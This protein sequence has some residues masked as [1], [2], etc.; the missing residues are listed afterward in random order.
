MRPNPE[1]LQRAEEAYEDIMIPARSDR[2]VQL[3]DA[4][5]TYRRQI[6]A[7][8]KAYWHAKWTIG[9]DF[10]RARLSAVAA[11]R[12]VLDADDDGAA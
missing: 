1:T 5:K 11:K 9:A 4:E 10:E 8:G 2:N 3:A 12:A 6:E 7:Y